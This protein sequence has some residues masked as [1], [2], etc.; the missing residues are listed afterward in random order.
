MSG[1]A[2]LVF[3][4]S[5]DLTVPN[6][7]FGAAAQVT[8]LG[9]GVLTLA[10]NNTFG[11]TAGGGLNLNAGTVKLGSA[12]ALGSGV[13]LNFDGGQLDL[14]G[15]NVT[16]GSFVS[17]LNGGVVRDTGPAGTSTLT[18]DQAVDGAFSGSIT[19]STR[20]IAL[21]KIGSGA[22][23]LT[24][25]NTFNGGLRITNGAIIAAGT[26]GNEPI[27]SN[28]TLGDGS[29]AVF[30]IAG[31]PGQQFGPTTSVTFTNESKDAK[32]MLRGTSQTLEG[33]DGTVGQSLSIIQNDEAGTPGYQ[34][35]AGL[36]T[37]T[38][39]TLSNHSF[40]GLIRNQEGGGLNIVKDGP[41]TQ[42]LVNVLVAT[43]QYGDITINN[44]KLS[45]FMIPNGVQ[46]NQLG[47]GNI[48]V[49]SP[50]TLV[51]DGDWSNAN[52]TPFTRVVS[53]NGNLIKQGPGIVNIASANSYTG[54]TT[55]NSGT[56]LVTGSVVGATIVNA[57]GI[58][59]GAGTL[60]AVNVAGGT[61]A[62]G[63]GIGT[64][65]TGALTLSAVSILKLG[66]TLGDTTAGG[67]INDLVM[68]NGNLTLD[69]TLRVTELG[70]PLSNDGVYTLMDYS[71]TLTDNGLTIDAGFLAVHPGAAIIIDTVNTQVLL[72]VP[73]PASAMSVLAGICLFAGL[74]RRRRDVE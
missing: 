23:T 39:N 49:N 30:L 31:A 34:G 26:S 10:G 60:D 53:G 27:R 56:L 32:L 69:G 47:A 63:N 50:G 17:T 2:T 51:L 24:G 3:N 58:L 40:A 38:L 5:D 19:Q 44:G 65:T 7:I 67:G 59:G 61:L 41:G 36:A 64:L 37:L 54:G 15:N 55:V 1:G 6:N 33:V 29:S 21:A 14:N 18:L 43:S 42:E 72:S 46:T 25:N 35:G 20:T 4:R 57:G 28:V 73:E 70:G 74:R 48:M 13:A 11:T 9:A 8:K 16:A 52:N 12:T 71:G 62:P 22:L 66:L 45:F 68:V